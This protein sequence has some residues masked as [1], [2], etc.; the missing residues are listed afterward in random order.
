MNK[1]LGKVIVQFNKLED[2]ENNLLH[3]G[4]VCKQFLMSQSVLC[5]LGALFCKSTY[6]A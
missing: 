3:K 5:Q 2:T 4:T 6:T 1:G